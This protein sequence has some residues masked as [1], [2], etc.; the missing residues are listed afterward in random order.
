MEWDVIKPTAIARWIVQ[1]HD[2]HFR[3]RSNEAEGTRVTILLLMEQ[4]GE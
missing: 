4:T 2:G 1:R 3:V